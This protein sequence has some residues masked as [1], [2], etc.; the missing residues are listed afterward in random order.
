MICSRNWNSLS[1]KPNMGCE[2]SFMSSIH[3]ST[4]WN[5]S[6]ATVQR[7]AWWVHYIIILCSYMELWI[8]K[9]RENIF[10]LNW[11]SVIL[12]FQVCEDTGPL[13]SPS[14]PGVR[15][16]RFVLSSCCKFDWSKRKLWCCRCQTL[17]KECMEKKDVI[18]QIL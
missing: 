3:W 8:L 12:H 1:N 15:P 17:D 2:N 10:Y 4:G 11:K 13:N 6:G 14:V 5:Y 16:L 9:I 18:V 7:N